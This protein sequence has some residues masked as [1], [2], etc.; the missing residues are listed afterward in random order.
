MFSIAKKAASVKS[1]TKH[2][3]FIPLGQRVKHIQIVEEQ[4][5]VESITEISREDF[6]I[7]DLVIVQS[8]GH[9]FENSAITSGKFFSQF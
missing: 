2:V 9:K 5:N 3:T 4:A 7:D 8:S 6:G 1:F